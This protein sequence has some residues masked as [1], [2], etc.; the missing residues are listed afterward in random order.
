MIP[1]YV[2]MR[3]KRDTIY[4]RYRCDMYVYRR[5]KRDSCVRIY[6]I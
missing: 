2:C 3:Y 5:Y 4:V 1:V 6:E